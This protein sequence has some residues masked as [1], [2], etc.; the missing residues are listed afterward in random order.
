MLTGVIPPGILGFPDL[1]QPAK[2]HAHSNNPNTLYQCHL[3]FELFDL[4]DQ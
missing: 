2:P 1:Q 3:L 4:V